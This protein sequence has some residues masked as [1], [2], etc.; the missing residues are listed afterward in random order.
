MCCKLIVGKRNGPV[1]PPRSW[2]TGEHHRYLH[3]YLAVAL[4]VPRGKHVEAWH[5]DVSWPDTSPSLSPGACRGSARRGAPRKSFLCLFRAEI[6]RDDLRAVHAGS[7][8]VP[9]S[10]RD[11]SRRACSRASAHARIDSRR[12]VTEST[13]RQPIFVSS[14]RRFSR[15]DVDNDG[16]SYRCPR[17]GNGRYRYRRELRVRSLGPKFSWNA[18]VPHVNS[19]ATVHALVSLERTRTIGGFVSRNLMRR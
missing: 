2:V 4:T 6:F 13:L 3:N 9:R 11:R 7:A 1:D 16:N 15:R 10:S 5:R 17:G 14:R 12:S 18:S 19:R 8:A